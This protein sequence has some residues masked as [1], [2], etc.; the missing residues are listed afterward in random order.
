MKP[1]K[2]RVDARHQLA[3]GKRLGHVVVGARI[4]AA[5]LVAVLRSRGQHDDRQHGI[6]SADLLAHREPVDVGQHQVQDH[7]IGEFTGDEL[8]RFPSICSFEDL[9]IPLRLQDASNQTPRLGRVIDHHNAR[10]SIRRYVIQR[11]EQSLL[12]CWGRFLPL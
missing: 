5:D 7:Q 2:D 12:G 11:G 9:K 4:Q 3:D 6:G 1:A 8:E 10:E